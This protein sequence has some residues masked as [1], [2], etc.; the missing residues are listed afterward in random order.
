VKT[1]PIFLVD[2]DEVRCVVVGGGKVAA[3]KVRA[4]LRADA[5]VIV[6]SPHLCE[7][8]RQ[9]A[10]EGEIEVLDRPYRCGDLKGAF[11][12]V[13]A[14]DDPAINERVWQE[15]MALGLLVNVV[16][17]P[18]HCN[19]IAPSVV[20]R[21]PLRF[22]ISTSGRCPA[23]SR[24]LRKQLEQEYPP[25]YGDYVEL[26]G[27][28]RECVVDALPFSARRDFWREVFA[29]NI[30]SLVSSGEHDE[31]RRRAWKMLEDHLSG[32]A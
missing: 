24:H 14:T 19:F 15:A 31:A 13:A 25:A 29:S 9:L 3:R 21:G 16:D 23:L 18:D 8:L 7:P 6:I 17:D 4:M 30:L 28:L 27:N 32:A 26:L 10:A 12:V 22:A 1:Y 2:L 5:R 20:R 11:L